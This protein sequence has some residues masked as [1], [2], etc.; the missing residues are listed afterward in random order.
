MIENLP[1]WIPVLFSIVS[2]ITI[3]GFYYAIG[4]R[5]KIISV[6]L[7]LMLIQGIM[8][9]S[10]FFLVVQSIP[11]RLIFMIIGGLVL[12]ILAFVTKGGHRLMDT[13]DYRALTYLQTIRIPV[14]FIIL[15]LFL[16]ELMPQTMTFEGRNFDIF[17]GI[18]APV[19]AYLG[20]HKKKLSTRILILW[21]ILCLAL[22]LQVVIT[23]ILSAP[24]VFQQRS[25][26]MPNTA[27]LYI[28]FVWLPGIIVPIVI[29]SH[30]A[31]IRHLLHV[32]KN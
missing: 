22:V 14:E 21:N 9:G 30:L 4:K 18:T 12:I 24:S 23:G 1:I 15:A 20:Y 28:P 19:I 27:I 26:D 6:I 3:I 31:S 10:G 2:L 7:M 13:I 25:F 11:P 17:S 32:N 8:A 29:F 5:L 16:H